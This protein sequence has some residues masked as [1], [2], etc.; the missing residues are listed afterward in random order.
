MTLR[1]V[2]GRTA[3]RQRL[4]RALRPAWMGTLRRTT[5]ISAHWGYDRGRP[6]DRYY[7]ERFVRA[8]R[9]DVRGA[10]LEVKEP[11]YTGRYGDAVSR[12]DVLDL[13]ASNPH[14]TIVAD[15]A[16]LA[17]VPH[18][19][20]DCCLIT[21]TLQYVFD[22]RAAVDALHR[23][24]RPGG[25]LLVTVPALT[26]HDPLADYPD[27]WR[28]TVD[29]CARLFGAVFGPSNVEVRSAGNVLASVAFLEGLAQEE[30]TP[31]ELDANDPLFPL[32]ITVRAVKAHTGGAA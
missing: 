31:A 5:P 28:F 1:S 29:S 14:A 7:I 23:V 24:L 9:A 11:L 26:R 13:S 10:V 19:I 16:S 20:F 17:P 25:V 8:H 4:R 12:V 30:L 3:M 27:Y 15:I 21:Q 32:V 6:I 18:G 2:A 22:P